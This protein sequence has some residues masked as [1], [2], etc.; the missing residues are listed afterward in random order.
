M[1]L[2]L[3]RKLFVINFLSQNLSKDS[4]KVG[5]TEIVVMRFHRG[6]VFFVQLSAFTGNHFIFVS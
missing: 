3:F 2:L 6:V 4:G 5:V 1:F